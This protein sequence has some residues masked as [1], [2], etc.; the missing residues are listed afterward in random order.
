VVGVD[1]GLAVELK[2]TELR[3]LSPDCCERRARYQQRL[4]YRGR[5]RAVPP[6]VY[7]L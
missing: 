3:V 5:T 2:Y 4:D 6:C 7:A 1:Q